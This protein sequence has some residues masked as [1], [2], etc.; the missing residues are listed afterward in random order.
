MSISDQQINDTVEAVFAKY[1]TD[2]SK[3]LDPSEVL[4]I[5]RDAFK[6]HNVGKEVTEAEVQNL[7][8]VVDQNGD[9][10]IQKNE[11]FDLFKKILA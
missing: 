1:D 10:K 7:I 8:K 11:L 2:G 3:S 9:G 6:A 5:V 4:N